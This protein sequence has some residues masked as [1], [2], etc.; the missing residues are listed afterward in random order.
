MKKAIAS[1]IF[2][3]LVVSVNAQQVAQYTNYMYNTL[4]INPA[5]AGS[6]GT[7][8]IFGL[9]RSQ[10]VGIE[11]APTTNTFAMHA[12][13]KNSN[14]GLG[15]SFVKDVVGPSDESAISVDFSY[16]IK[17]SETY[18]LA[19]GLRSSANLLNIDFSK[20]NIYNPGDA[21]AQFNVENKFSPNFGIGLYWY[22]ENTYFGA[23][24]PNMLE[25]KYFD[26]GQTTNGASSVAASKRHY[27][28][29]AG[30][31][32]DLLPSL[33]FKPAMLIKEVEGS[34]LQMDV[35]ANFLYNEKLT[36][37]AAYR[38]NSAISF[39]T[40]FQINP[41]WFIGYGYDLEQTKLTNNNF[42]S[43]EFFLRYEFAR[44]NKVLTPRFF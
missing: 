9:H 40:G 16:T 19:L 2:V 44:K 12:P 27:H 34:P 8:S 26:S 35:S 31:V 28:F 6:R 20:L 22:S 39:L 42:G 41:N 43:H 23:S 17:T 38:L 32:L 29:I 10:W 33:Q 4:N 15:L 37:G 7:A 21:L 5:Y 36:I 3:S 30:H 11:G 18:K 14:V 1:L 25:T 24:I 13:L